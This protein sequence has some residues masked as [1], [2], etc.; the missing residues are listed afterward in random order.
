MAEIL[1]IVVTVYVVYVIHSV[2]TEHKGKKV[3]KNIPSEPSSVIRGVEKIEA[4]KE[5]AVAKKAVTKK[6]NNKKAVVKKE[7][8]NKKNTPMPAGSLRDPKTGED[9]KIATSYR[10]LRRWIKDALV[11]EGLLEKIY[12]T[13]EL[14]DAAVE[15]IN[16]ALSTLQKMKGYQ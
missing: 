16:K 7:K 8:Q 4:K 9:V 1:F 6:T 13:N 10:M 5:K 11:K 14:D 2:V 12:K 3:E 15:K